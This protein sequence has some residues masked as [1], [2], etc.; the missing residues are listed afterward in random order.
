MGKAQ[1]PRDNNEIPDAGS[2]AEY[3]SA[4]A[5]ELG[6]ALAKI[7]PEQIEAAYDVL[8]GALKSG[9]RIYVA[10]NGG[11]AAIS[12]H[13]CCDWLKGTYVPGQPA[14][15]VHSL[16]ANTALF[17]AL[18]NDFGYDATIA[19]Q[20]EMLG[21]PGDVLILI[22]SSGNS[23]NIIKAADSAR[24]RKMKVIGMTGFN[25]GKLA[26]SADVSLYVP[27]HNYGMAEDAHQMLMHSLAQFL[28]K[29][30]DV[31]R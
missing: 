1:D 25:G 27:A 19:R 14:L 5:R 12:D 30:R 4:Y 6:V 22:S 11:S 26:A 20:V 10:G 8:R 29:E 28:N 31:S 2:A 23:A 18:G 21:E 13:L 16:T 15:K 17:T 9:A 7:S 3:F 24:A